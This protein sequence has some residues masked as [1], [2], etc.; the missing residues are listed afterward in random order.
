MPKQTISNQYAIYLRKSRKDVQMEALGAGETLARHRKTLLELAGSMK[1]PVTKLYSEVVSGDSIAARPQM[2]QLLADVAAGMYA[3]VFVMEVE[4]LARGDTKDQGEVMEVF[5]SSGTKIITPVKTYDPLNESDEEYL[6]FGLFMS[7]REYK[8]IARRQQKGRITSVSEG[9][10]IAGT[11]PYGYKKVKLKGKGFSLAIAEDAAQTIRLIFDLYT[12]GQQQEDGSC[13]RLGTTAIA[14]RLDELRIP[15]PSGAPTWSKSTVQDILKNP[16]YAGMIRWGYRKVSKE[17]DADGSVSVHR[18]DNPDCHLVE[19][20]HPAII[21]PDQFKLAEEIRNR[22]RRMPV[23]LVPRDHGV[24]ILQNPLAGICFCGKCGSLMTRLGPNKRNLYDTLRCSNRY[25]DNISAPIY[26]VEQK[27][28]DFL[29]TWLEQYRLQ[30]EDILPPDDSREMIQASI[31][32]AKKD[33][34]TARKQLDATYTLLE[35]G[36]YTVD[37]FTQRNT[38]ITATVADLEK[39]LADLQTQY[40]ASSKIIRLRQDFIPRMENVLEAYDR[41]D[42][43][44]GKNDLLR[45]VVDRV[46]YLKTVPNR[47]GCR[48]NANFELKVWPRMP[49]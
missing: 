7:R 39:Q 45:T 19:G 25:C 18:H 27:L 48:D 31:A 4:R 30:H 23:K 5:R 32:G 1:L 38:A 36:I 21:S 41:I 14:R 44:S 15:T 46:E 26:L 6:E 11:A 12:K 28:L 17:R 43:A 40:E 37:V 33:L 34:E 49:K 3:G 22:N 29:A 8:T 10:Y 13:C 35:Q 9:F 2:Q 24:P 42:T 20:K 47:R 16:T